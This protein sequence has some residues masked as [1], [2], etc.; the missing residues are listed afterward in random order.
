ML[1]TALCESHAEAKPFYTLTQNALSDGR[2][3]DYLRT[4]YGKRI[5]LPTTNEVQKAIDEY[6]A[7]ALRRYKQGQLKP[8]EDVQAGEVQLNGPVPVIGI[9]ALL[10]KVILE[11]NCKRRRLQQRHNQRQ[12]P[13]LGQAR[14]QR[15]HVHR[16]LFSQWHQLD[17]GWKHVVDQYR[18][19]RLGGHRPQQF[20]LVRGKV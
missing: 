20:I 6:K 13:L 19:Y 7:D 12:R 9:H 3:M 1:V 14:A 10:V 5:N 8:G 17:A 4:M 2:Y 16:I 15:Q 18:L 11:H